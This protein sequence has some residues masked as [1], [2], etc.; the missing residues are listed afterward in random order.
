MSFRVVAFFVVYFFSCFPVSAQRTTQPRPAV[1]PAVALVR[2]LPP[3]QRIQASAILSERDDSKRADL[4]EDLAETGLARAFI[5]HLLETDPSRR[6]RMDIIG[7][8][9][10]RPDSL[11]ALERRV[12]TDRDV[13]VA[14]KALDKLR[15]IRVRQV[16]QLLVKRIEASKRQG[17]KDETRRLAQEQERWISLANGTMLPGFLRVPPPVFSV[18]PNDQPVRL[19]AFGDFGTGTDQQKEVAAAMLKYHQRTPFDF[20]ITLGDNFYSVGMESPSDPRWKTWWE[21]V[22]G[23][24]NIKFYATLGNHDWRHPD[25]PASEVWY[26]QKSDIWRMPSPYYTFTAGPVQFFALDTTE[27]SEAQLI[28]LS[29][30]LAKSE[31]QW[32]V[33]HGHHP[34][35]S[36]G[37]HDDNTT[38][39][40]RLLPILKKQANVYLAGHD[41]DLQHLRPEDGL[42]FF[43]AGGGGANLRPMQ[44]D[45]RS[46]FAKSAYG[47]AVIEAESEQ[48]KVRFVAPDLQQLYEYTLT[49]KRPTEAP[50]AKQ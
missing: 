40:K 22:Y 15:T 41:H 16:G 31:A 32:K 4:A 12:A 20:A 26:T 24:M 36:A 8:L 5:L 49:R 39:V 1:D 43:V 30:E 46:L 2:R 17:L 44:T 28:W 27:V 6:V 47:F 18:K 11:K 38:L 34:I 29:D 33:V 9:D 10:S 3:A 35:F 37:A 50:P 14:L 13:E 23:P 45:P 25:S 19:L 21:D 48:L 42:H 7:K